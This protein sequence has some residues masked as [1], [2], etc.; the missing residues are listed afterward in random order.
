MP[1]GGISLD[2]ELLG[3]RRTM[4]HREIWNQKTLQKT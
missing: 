1:V 2:L 4:F 3:T